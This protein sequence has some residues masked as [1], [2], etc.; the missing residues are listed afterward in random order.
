MFQ[1]AYPAHFLGGVYG[2]DGSRLDEV[3]DTGWV[4]LTLANCNQASG[5]AACAV[6]VKESVVFVRGAVT[7]SAS[8]TSSSTASRQPTT[9]PA[10][11]RPAQNMLVNSGPRSNYACIEID[12]DGA[13]KL[14]NRIGAAL[15]TSEVISLSA[16]F[17]V[18]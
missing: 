9:L 10:G 14:W 6:R 1:S 5:W 4:A 15:G 16:V 2:A 7:L 12:A 17:P 3:H 11:C 8:M 13:V 18:D